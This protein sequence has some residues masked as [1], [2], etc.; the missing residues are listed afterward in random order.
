M[1]HTTPAHSVRLLVRLHHRPGTLGRFA[2]AVGDLGGNITRL[3]GFEVKGDSIT[4]EI[5]VDAESEE[6][7]ALILAGLGDLPGV[8]ILESDDLVFHYHRGGKLEVVGRFPLR[9]RDDLSIAYTPGV[10]RVC[11]AIA[12]DPALA[13]TYT[14]RGSMIAVVS[15]GTA[16]LG[17]G[18]IGP[19]ASLPVMEGK[20][21][22]F[23]EFGGVDAVPIVLATTDPDEIVETVVRIAPSFAGVN[24]EDIAAPACFVIEDRLRELLD[25]PIFHDD[26][27]G[28]AIVVL[29]ALEN[30]CRVTGRSMDDLRVVIAGAGAAGVAIA[31]ILAN[32]G[33]ADIVVTDSRG[34]VHAGRDGLD[35]G[36]AWLAANTN[37]GG[38]DGTLSEALAGADVFIGVSRPDIV[39]RDD[40]AR[41]APRPLVFALSNPDPEIVPELIADLAG[42]IATGRSD[43]PN[44]INNV[45]AFPGVFRGA[46]DAGATTITE[47][48]KLAAA[49]AIAAAVGDDLRPDRIVPE[50]LD[51]SIAPLVA[52]AVAGAARA[53][54]VVR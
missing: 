9:D 16:V 40:V 23:K 20:A 53:E 15:D 27:H 25:I 26:Q 3:S 10:A 6:H 18:D 52:E 38:L 44:Q 8:D 14:S 35:H 37:P 21:M 2:T 49:Q 47:G 24:L 33:V 17:L 31:K 45:L 42:V 54:G 41:M 4:R 48:M 29:A 46:L 13:W 7:V 19:L 1:A 34:T 28:T 39:T 30:A 11:L 51:R 50:A 22:L 12:D 5:V 43:Y 32:A 36:K